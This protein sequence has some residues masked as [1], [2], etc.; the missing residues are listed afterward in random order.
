MKKLADTTIKIIEKYFEQKNIP[1]QIREITS[2]LY[3]IIYDD[4][5]LMDMYVY[6]FNKNIKFS[7]LISNYDWSL[8]LFSLETNLDL[9]ILINK[10]NELIKVIDRHK[11]LIE[12]KNALR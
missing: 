11:E 2:T 10:I 5:T 4:F 1:I 8:S 7:S 9:A 6:T 12:I 3:F